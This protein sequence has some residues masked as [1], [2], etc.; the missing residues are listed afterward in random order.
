MSG[1]S[2]VI[3]TSVPGKNYQVWTTTNLAVPFSPL[4]GIITAS[5]L[6]T[7]YTNSPA[8]V[9]RYYRVQLFP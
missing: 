5:G 6:T 1:S 3:W 2:V 4:S 8:D 7:C 9:A